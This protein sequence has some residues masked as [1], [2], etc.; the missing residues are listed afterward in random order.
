MTITILPSDPHID[1]MIRAVLVTTADTPKARDCAL[2]LIS[3]LQRVKAELAVARAQLF[4]LG[5][6]PQ[7]PN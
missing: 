7:R 6:E 2:A 3:E 4:S 1:K 5:V